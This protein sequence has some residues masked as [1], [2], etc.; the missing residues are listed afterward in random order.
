MTQKTFEPSIC[1]I[2]IG[3]HSENAGAIGVVMENVVSSRLPCSDLNRGDQYQFIWSILAQ[4]FTKLGRTRLVAFRQDRMDERERLRSEEDWVASTVFVL[5]SILLLI[6]IEFFSC[7]LFDL[8]LQ[9][10]WHTAT[11]TFFSTLVPAFGE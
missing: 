9:C 5:V 4:C 11:D 3:A 8:F 7:D 1:S 2:N 10:H 6:N